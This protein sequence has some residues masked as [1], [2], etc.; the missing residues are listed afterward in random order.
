MA[1]HFCR[2]DP[3]IQVSRALLQKKAANSGWQGA[4]A[5]E[6]YKFRLAASFC[7]RDWQ[8][9]GSLSVSHDAF[10]RVGWRIHHCATTHEA[11]RRDVCQDIG[12]AEPCDSCSKSFP[13]A[14]CCSALQCIAVRC[15]SVV[16]CSM[17]PVWKDERDSSMLQ[18]FTVRMLQCVTESHLFV[19]ASKSF[20]PTTH[21]SHICF[22]WLV[23]CC[24]A[25]QQHIVTHCNIELLT[26]LSFYTDDMLQRAAAHYKTLQQ[27]TVTHSN[28]FES[29]SSLHSGNTM[30]R[31]AT[32][33]SALQQPWHSVLNCNTSDPNSS[34]HTWQY[35]AVHCSTLSALQQHAVR[36]GNTLQQIWGTC[37]GY[38]EVCMYI[39]TYMCISRIGCSVSRSRMRCSVSQTFCCVSVM[40]GVAVCR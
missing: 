29:R 36:Q 30:Q 15:S 34:C 9:Q 31:T 11:H 40:Q 27:H 18:W 17:L 33:C 38:S 26:H 28:I 32:H 21:S 8:I 39:Y 35:A 3:H 13:P 20:P 12:W 10:L 16:R 2:S 19:A 7:K 25:L 1:G 23:T 14:C 22:L 5:K 37:R 24:S 6:N 4:F